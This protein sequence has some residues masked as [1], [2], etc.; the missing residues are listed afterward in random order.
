M[1]SVLDEASIDL[2]PEHPQAS[3]GP[4]D[5]LLPGLQMDVE[6]FRRR[7]A[8]LE[9]A[10]V[11]VRAELIYGVVHM[12]P[13]PDIAGHALPQGDLVTVLGLYRAKTP[14]VRSGGEGGVGRG[15]HSLVGAD[16]VLLVEPEC[17]GQMV[18]DRDGRLTGVPELVAEIANTL[19]GHDTITKRALYQ[20]A[21]VREYLVHLVQPRR[22]AAFVRESDACESG[23]LV[24]IDLSGGIFRSA[25][26]PGLW[27]DCAA[28]AAG[29]LAAA[30]DTLGHGTAT[31]EHAAFA[32]ALR[33]RQEGESRTA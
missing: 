27:I 15:G 14:G 18:R 24:E 3:V 4:S 9:R 16:V 7:G 31:P 22:F 29:D 17:G 20:D 1:A 13:P 6:E 11:D 32:D 5:R 2:P 26:F 30:I 33:Q 23:E 28:L 8:V 12:M 25:V 10:G 19:A 21:G